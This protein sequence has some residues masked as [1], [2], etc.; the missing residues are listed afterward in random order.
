[1]PFGLANAPT[2]FQSYI[3]KCLAEKLDVF[4]IIYLD[5][6]L[7]YTNEIGARH[8][9]AVRWILGQFCKFDLYANLK[10]CQFGTDKVLFLGYIV[11][12]S[13]VQIELERIESIKNWPEP[14][15][16]KEIQVFI[17]FANFYRWF[18][19]NFSAIAGPLTSMLKTDLGFRS[20]K[21]I[22]KILSPRLRSKP[23]LS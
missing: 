22:K 9:E 19:R 2:T 7:I 20:S 18:I 21:S 12:P 11:S 16:I 10:K 14:Q 5:S 15:S 3:N 8:E 13:G 1:M 23:P 6:I 17:G 4:C